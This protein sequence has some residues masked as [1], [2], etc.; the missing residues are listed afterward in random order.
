MSK[1]NIAQL[2]LIIIITAAFAFYIKKNFNQIK[3]AVS[4]KPYFLVLLVLLNIANKVCLGLKTKKILESFNIR[5]LF[6]EWFGMSCV[7][8]FYNYLAPKSGT[9]ACGLYLKNKYDLD[10]NKYMGILITTGLITILASGLVGFA[11]SLCSGLPHRIDK[12]IF[13]VLFFGMIAGSLVLFL[14]PRIKLPEKGLFVKINEFFEGWEVL[15]KDARTITILSFWDLLIILSMAARYFVLFRIFSLP[16][17]FTSCVLI[18]PFNII[19]HFMSIVPGA[20]GIKEAAVGAVSTLTDVS[21]ASGALATL[22]DRIITMT[23]T[24][25]LGPVFS[26]I[27]LRHGF[28]KK[29]G[30]LSHE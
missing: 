10:Y 26:F 30:A 11:F 14:M 17:T 12:I 21:F 8:N 24:F 3:E 27:L 9:A 23:L 18:A 16:V 1:K 5:L 6:K 13:L 4:I 25:I 22:T 20:Y 29:K 28:D 19:T 2:V 7:N 15:R